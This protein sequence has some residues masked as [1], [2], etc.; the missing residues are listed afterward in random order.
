MIDPYSLIYRSTNTSNWV[1]CMS[2]LQKINDNINNIMW[3]K[4]MEMLYWED[5]ILRFRRVKYQLN[6]LKTQKQIDK[7]TAIEENKHKYVTFKRFCDE[8]EDYFGWRYRDEVTDETIQEI[9]D[10]LC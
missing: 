3:S 8:C 2:V 1:W 6:R 4:G 9:F 10:N 7:Y 5:L